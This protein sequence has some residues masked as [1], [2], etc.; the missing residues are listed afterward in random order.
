VTGFTAVGSFEGQAADLVRGALS[1]AAPSK[2]LPILS[3]PMGVEEILPVVV[4]GQFTG[5]E[6]GNEVWAVNING[7]GTLDTL[8]QYNIVDGEYLFAIAN[9]QFGG[10]ASTPEPSTLI[11]ALITLLAVLVLQRKRLLSFFFDAAV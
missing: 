1:F 8:G 9:Y 4:T 3:G 10:L 5:F 6:G 11:Q 7:T 2:F